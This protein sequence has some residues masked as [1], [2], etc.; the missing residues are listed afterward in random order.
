[1]SGRKQ[2]R[3]LST[4]GSIN[5]FDNQIEYSV[6]NRDIPAG[7]VDLS[8]TFSSLKPRQE[9]ARVKSP[10][11]SPDA[12]SMPSSTKLEGASDIG[13][14]LASIASGIVGGRARRREQRQA[15]REY[16]MMRERYMQQDIGNVYADL[17]NPYEDLT[18]NQQASE[19]AKQ[20]RQQA[21]A[22]I[23]QGLQGSAGGS[24][25]AAL[26]QSLAQQEAQAAQAASADIA[27]Q[28]ARNQ[29]LTA[30]GAMRL[31]TMERIGAESALQREQERT[32]TLFG[33]AQQRKARADLAREQATQA[34]IGGVGQTIGGGAKLA[35]GV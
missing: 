21:T 13:Q 18:V 20:Q 6:G 16:Q 31:Q 26:A 12:F 14:G 11:I 28:E 1:M 2:T 7:S 24:G 35:F 3:E 4:S 8:S 15:N 19:F 29:A 22:N 17:Q 27:S 32:E 10:L 9:V 23:M 33:M 5:P 25:I 34:I 30:Q